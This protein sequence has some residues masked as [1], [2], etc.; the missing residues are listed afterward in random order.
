MT[1]NKSLL[2]IFAI[3][4][5]VVFVCGTQISFAKD[6]PVLQSGT[7]SLRVG[8]LARIEPVSRV[9]TLASPNNMDGSRIGSWLVQEGD[10]VQK[11]DLL[12][13]FS[14][15]GRELA[16]KALADARVKVAQANLVRIQQGSKKEDIEAQKA[17]VNAAIAQEDR[18][19]KEYDRSLQMYQ[20]KAISKS[21]YDLALSDYKKTQAD[22]KSA[23]E[24]LDSLMTVRPDDVQIAQAQVDEAKA[25]AAVAAE[26]LAL[27][28]IRAPINGTILKIYSFEGEAPADSGILDIADLTV[29]DAVAEVFENDI[30]KVKEGQS[31]SITVPGLT[32]PLHG[33]VVLVGWQVGKN[34]IVDSN[35][36]RLL[37]TRVIEVRIRID[38][39]ESAALRH[40]IDVKSTVVIE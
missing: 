34:N 31:V 22:R 24:V 18:A 38:P 14:H 27:S 7:E 28:E 39:K 4:F 9:L 2:S 19:R 35:P 1:K 26:S 10:D 13:Y 15:H 11:G 40:L 33:K 23:Q 6:D 16:Q 3:A 21:R 32:S 30:T 36:T 5:A 8:A 12:G 25:Q 20:E 29:F 37:D 17:R